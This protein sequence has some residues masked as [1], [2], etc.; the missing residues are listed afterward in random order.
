ML[1]M[2]HMMKAFNANIMFYSF[3]STNQTAIIIIISAKKKMMIIFFS[4]VILLL[5]FFIYV[6]DDKHGYV[7]VSSIVCVRKTRE[8]S[9][10]PRI[11]P[12]WCKCFFFFFLF[13]CFCFWPKKT[14][15]IHN[16]SHIETIKIDRFFFPI[17]KKEDRILDILSRYSKKWNKQCSLL[18][19]RERKK[20]IKILAF[21]EIFSSYCSGMK[22]ISLDDP[23]CNNKFKMQKEID[24]LI[25]K[26]LPE[27]KSCYRTIRFM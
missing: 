16:G 3:L 5:L 6:Q 18:G 1:M 9:F 2:I 17:K 19:K 4:P 11:N 13:S 23:L 27:C 10:N 20:K 7:F 15:F 21:I 24:R 14:I 22:G 25:D 8:N 26:T 12:V